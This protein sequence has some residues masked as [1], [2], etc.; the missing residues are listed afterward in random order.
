MRLF[1]AVV[2][3]LLL[4]CC[5]QQ[6]S[7]TIQELSKVEVREY[8]GEKLSSVGDFRENSIAGLQKVNI[9]SYRLQIAGLVDD[10]QSY[11]YSQVL[12]HQKYGKVVSL[13]CVEGWSANILWEGIL[14][15]DLLDE[16]GVKPGANTVIFYAVDGYSTSLPL[17]YILDRNILLAYGLNN[18][19]L[20]AERGFPFELVAEDKWGYKW[21]KWVERI[22][23][24]NDPN[25]R[26]YW[27]SR[28]YSNGGNLSGSFIG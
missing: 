9:T 8:Q 16:A 17:S 21:I 12:G 7:E 19:T 3:A 10:P 23:L 11:S 20:P 6:K 1:F 4:C 27:E 22:E 25:Y 2:C 18:V 26:G 5:L 28:G 14:V 13:H 24:S 15:K